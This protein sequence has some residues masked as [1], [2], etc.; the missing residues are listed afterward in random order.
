MFPTLPVLEPVQLDPIA[1]VQKINIEEPKPEPPKSVEYIIKPNDTL[2]KIAKAHTT[3]IERLWSANLQLE[4]PD[5]IEANKPLKIPHNEEIL[6][7]RPLPPP[8]EPAIVPSTP[9]GA[10]PALTKQKRAVVAGNT[11]TKGYCTWH[12]KNLR[13]DLPN[14]LGNADTWYIR[15]TGPKGYAPQV[16]AVGVAVSYMHVVYVI[17]VNGDSVT[18]S[19]MNYKGWNVASTRVASASEFRYIY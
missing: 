13:P 5:R 15:Y 2:E 3:S 16:G 17:A 18:V 1:I 19:E 4:H 9:P 14:N 10:P 8:S 11:Y 7:D 6:P 12:V